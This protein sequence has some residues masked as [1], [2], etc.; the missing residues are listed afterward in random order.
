MLSSRA[1]C[2]SRSSTLASIS[3]AAR[4]H[5][6]RFLVRDRKEIDRPCIAISRWH[7]RC[8]SEPVEMRLITSKRGDEPRAVMARIGAKPSGDQ[9]GIPS[10]RL[11]PGQAAARLW[12][13]AMLRQQGPISCRAQLVAGRAPRLPIPEPQMPEHSREQSGYG[14]PGVSPLGAMLK[15]HCHNAFADEV[16]STKGLAKMPEQASACCRV[17]TACAPFIEMK[18]SRRLAH[19]GSCRALGELETGR[20]KCPTE[21]TASVPPEQSCFDLKVQ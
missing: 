11:H 2:P 16:S 3:C 21:R 18:R 7:P 10:R 15:V 8:M 12:L 5:R 14:T 19:T 13:Q 6:R 9:Y 20:Q 17:P 1:S 4:A